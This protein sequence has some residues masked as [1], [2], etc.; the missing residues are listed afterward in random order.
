[1]CHHTKD[2][3]MRRKKVEGKKIKETNKIRKFG[4][5]DKGRVKVRGIYL[6]PG[7]AKGNRG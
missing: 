7:L 1:M 3:V 6:C 2:F 5:W 4:V